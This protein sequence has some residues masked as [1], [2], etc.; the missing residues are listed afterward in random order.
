M[1]EQK[2]IMLEDRAQALLFHLLAV[3]VRA[4]DMASL[5]EMGRDCVRVCREIQKEIETP[6]AR[7]AGLPARPQRPAPPPPEEVF[8]DGDELRWDI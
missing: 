8:E 3:G 2:E 1:S 7:A 6:T 5:G 4:K